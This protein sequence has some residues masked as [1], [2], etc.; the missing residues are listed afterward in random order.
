[1]KKQTT[2]LTFFLSVIISLTV[3]AQIQL[4][5]PKA[6]G[7]MLDVT[8][9]E[10]QEDVIYALTLTNHVVTS[11]DGGTTWGILYSDPLDHYARL[12]DLKLINN[13]AALSFNVV[14]EGSDYNKIIVFDLATA[15]ITQ[16]FSPPNSFESDI[17]IESYDISDSNN[18]VVLMHTTYSLLGAYTHEV[19]YT[20]NGGLNWNSIYY[21][22]INDNVAINNVSISPEDND[23]LFLMR[24]GSTSRELGGVFVSVDAG[25]TWE[26]KIPGNTY[27]AIAFNPDNSDDILLGTSYG[28][29]THIENLYRSLDGGETWAIVPMT[30][31]SMANDNIIAITFNPNNA[32]EIIVLEEN[33][34]VVSSDNGTTWEN[35]VYTTIDPETY[36]F[37]LSASYNPFVADELLI[38][39][40]FYPFLTTD[41]GVTLEKLENPF[42]N[43]TGIISA[44]SSADEKHIYYGMRS[45]YMHKDLQNDTEEG[46]YLQSL[47]QGF[48]SAVKVFADPVV[49]GRV[50]TGNRALN[51]SYINVSSAHGLEPK[52]IASSMFFLILEDVSTSI[53]NPNI[54]WISTGLELHRVDL[55][56]MDNIIDE[57]IAIP[58]WGEVITA[59]QVDNDAATTI[60]MTQGVD[61]YKSTDDGASW[62][63]SNNGLEHL[64]ARDHLILDIEQNPLN[65]NQL[66]LSSTDGIYLS[67]N[68][69]DSWV[70]ISSEF[71][72]NVAFSS[73]TENT[74]VGVTHYSDGFNVPLPIAKAKIVI[75]TDLGS[76]W[77]EISPEMLNYPFT[78][79][80]AF[81]FAENSVSVYLGVHDLGLI[82]YDIDLATLSVN[83]EV[84]YDN[85]IQI[86]P[87]PTPHSFSIRSAASVEAV[88][89]YTMTGKKVKTVTQPNTAIDISNLTRGVYLIEV[90]TTNGTITKRLLKSN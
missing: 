15:T 79:S 29:D 74:I 72:D 52:I 48:G 81:L 27:D 13:G 62:T 3:T 20:S 17:L 65:T 75:S 5:A 2:L 26:N 38:T 18:D 44:Y 73:V 37:G 71:T 55:T 67:E 66:L 85:S 32:N 83:S 4:E 31:T 64:N 63:L 51:T 86:Y 54:S 43:A 61:F 56:D 78:E 10:T 59:V 77:S 47:T 12:K 58:E 84:L 57:N 70:S 89:I 6:Y 24:G 19:F 14:A 60:F 41:G 1:M 16:T 40:N 36:Y 80:S 50:F 39:T 25:Q 87:N 46:H 34:M 11:V 69:G 88:N 22:V 68:K 45:G 35:Y 21:S 82:K 9:S 49:P 42:V 23:K 30:W 7:Q 28:Y 33:E 8:Y 53:A 76:T 90:K